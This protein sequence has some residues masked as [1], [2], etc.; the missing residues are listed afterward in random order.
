MG[1]KDVQRRALDE[2]EELNELND[3]FDDFVEKQ[4]KNKRNNKEFV[5]PDNIKVTSDYIRTVSKVSQDFLIKH[6]TAT[7][8]MLEGALKKFDSEK[9]VYFKQS[10]DSVEDYAPSKT[11]LLGEKKTKGKA[12]H[13]NAATTVIANAQRMINFQHA[14]AIVEYLKQNFAEKAVQ[15]KSH[16]E[17][18]VPINSDILW[19]ALAFKKSKKWIETLSKG[20]KAMKEAFSEA[21]YKEFKGLVDRAGKSD[22]YLPKEALEAI[23]DGSGEDVAQYFAQYIKGKNVSGKDLL[24]YTAKLQGAFLDFGLNQF[25]KA[26]L[27]TGSFFTNNRIGNQIMLAAK[28]DN[29]Q[30]YVKST[31]K[32]LKAKDNVPS[33]IMTSLLFSEL[34]NF[35]GKRKYTGWQ[36]VDNLLNLMDGHYYDLKG[37]PVLEQIGKGAFNLCIGMPNKVYNALVNKVMKFNEAFEKFE[38]KQAYFQELSKAEK[39]GIFKTSSKAL[40]IE[41]LYKHLDDNPHLKEYIV[42]KVNDVLGDYDQFSNVEKKVFKRLVPFYSWHRTVFRHTLKLAQENPTRFGL[43]AWKLYMMNNRDDGRPDWQSGA[44]DNIFGIKLPKGYVINKKDVMPYNT[45]VKDVSR[46]INLIPGAPKIS[47]EKFNAL[48]DVNPLIKATTEAMLGKK[49]F[50]G[51]PEITSKNW[52]QVTKN[53]KKGYFNTKTKKFVEGTP[54]SVRAGYVGKNAL[55][56]VYPHLENPVL[57]GIFSLDEIEKKGKFP[58]KMYDASFGGYYN[59]EY[60]GK[61]NGKTKR[62]SAKMALPL[63]YQI[64]NRV[65]GLGIQKDQKGADKKFKKQQ[66]KYNKKRKKK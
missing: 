40:T 24:H 48:D 13:G 45:I 66:E 32:A 53:K 49:L 62:R 9:G 20:D 7:P 22:L 63:E 41:Q 25:K 14:E 18:Y 3:S 2:I 23:I 50:A 60:I 59:K 5:I 1:R 36:E 17:N 16:P 42:E 64:A 4:V 47:K 28:S 10:W 52:K 21:D 27:A 26:V 12:A 8:E 57:K 56:T 19:N 38:R 44:L 61:F 65:L 35:G 39:A 34:E 29:L 51:S 33:E 11:G 37:K 54:A 46:V 43:I 15:G 55:K 58:D 6:K 30:D 31:Y